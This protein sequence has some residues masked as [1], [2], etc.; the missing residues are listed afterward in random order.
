MS[1]PILTAVTSAVTSAATADTIRADD[2]AGTAVISPIADI[3]TMADI[4]RHP[5]ASIPIHHLAACRVRS[6]A[7]IEVGLD[8]ALEDTRLIFEFLTDADYDLDHNPR[9]LLS[10]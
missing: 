9:F 2:T 4:E 3:A 8:F 10:L 1:Q 6:G 7:V 5:S